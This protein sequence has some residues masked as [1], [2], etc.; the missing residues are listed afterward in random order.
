MQ[1]TKQNGAGADALCTRPALRLKTSTRP[2][3]RR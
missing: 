2:V 1:N 3:L